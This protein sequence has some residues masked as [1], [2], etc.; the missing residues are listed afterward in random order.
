MP[1]T[2][3]HPELN[4]SPLM[5][6]DDHRKYQILLGM[7]QWMVTIGKPELYQLVSSLNR[8][9]KFP[10]KGYLDLDVHSFGYIKTTL[11]KQI[12]IDSRPMQF[13]RSDPKFEKLIPDF[14]KDHLESTGALSRVL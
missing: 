1:I 2:H 3:C 14:L 10:R 13:R 8:F 7:L 9:G 12:T 6:L 11:H 5:G 4:T